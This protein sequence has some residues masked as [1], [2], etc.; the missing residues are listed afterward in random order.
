MTRP[1]RLTLLPANATL[2]DTD[3][4]QLECA[5]GETEDPWID[6]FIRRLNCAIEDVT[7]KN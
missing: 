1:E 7:R 3:D 5:R 6:D 4:R 2:A